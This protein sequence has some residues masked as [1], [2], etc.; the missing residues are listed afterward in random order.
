MSNTA[1]KTTPR[2]GAAA[3]TSGDSRRLHIAQ[4]VGLKSNGLRPDIRR[5]KSHLLAAI[6]QLGVTL[7]DLT[8]I[9]VNDEK[10]SDLHLRYSGIEGTTDVLTFDL[11]DAPPLP[12]PPGEGRG[13]G[14]L[15]HDARSIEGEIYICHDEAIRQA[16]ER[17]HDVQHE[18]LLYALHGVLHLM[19]YDDHD[20]ADHAAMHAEEDRVLQAIGVGKVFGK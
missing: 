3:D 9:I 16:T 18:L 13:E 5:L 19:G 8:I 11:C 1:S 4:A 6:A 12:L 20:P 7:E 14:T 2:R 15:R 17:R 10:M